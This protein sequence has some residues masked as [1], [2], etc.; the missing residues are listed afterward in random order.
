[1]PLPIRI[2]LVATS[3]PGNIGAVARAMKNMGL[4]DLALV[5][6]ESFPNAAATARASGAADL[7]AAARVHATLAEA[8]G[9]CG[10]VIGTT[11]RARQLNWTILEP[12]EAAPQILAAAGRGA[13]AIVFG[14]E[15]AGL[16]NDELA[17]CN[18]LVTIPTA[19]EYASLNLAM[20][21]QILVYELWLAR[22][23]GTGAID[24][25]DVPLASSDEV[26]RLYGHLEQVLDEIEF[27]DR[28]GRGHLMARI[29]RL[30]NRA[31]LDQNEL[32]ILRGILT[33]VQG[34]R[35]PAGGRRRDRAQSGT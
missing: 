21:V 27:R 10:L 13:A 5:A 15:R 34:R 25:R 9:D 1:M 30:F 6:P 35:R 16:T 2:V 3:H 33:A 14:S 20:A 19:T 23:T 7:L 31:V 26:E 8:V 24:V 32:N 4:D 11:A 18:W 22:R 28:T 17:L 29:R 12:R